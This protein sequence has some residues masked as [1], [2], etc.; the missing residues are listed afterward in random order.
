MRY[1][2]SQSVVKATFEYFRHCGAGQRECQALWISSWKE[3]AIISEVIHPQ[4]SSTAVG[5]Q[6]DDD[7]MTELWARLALHDKGVCI[8]VHTHPGAAFHSAID[9]AFPII[10]SAG[11]L[12]LVIPNFGL[13]SIGFD[14]AFLAEIQVDGG[15]S[16]VAVSDRM[17]LI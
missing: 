14:K 1:R 2:V 7:W 10:R 6:L 5:F 4:H 11:F 9:D 3:R 8:Q 13:G 15:W 17:E 12:S 16:A